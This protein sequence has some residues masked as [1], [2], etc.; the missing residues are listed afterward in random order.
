MNIL[1]MTL[2]QIIQAIGHNM[3]IDLVVLSGA[4]NLEAIV[5]QVA[6]NKGYKGVV[7]WCDRIA[8]VITFVFDVVTTAV[9][10]Q[11][12]KAVPLVFLCF[13]LVFSMGCASSGANG[14]CGRISGQGLT[15]PYVGGKANV[16]G[17]N[18]HVGCV[19]KCTPDV[20]DALT[21]QMEAYVDSQT[22][23]GKIMTTSPGI[24]TFTPSK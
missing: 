6:V 24:I 1:D 13:G 21:A 15:V 11:A 2:R 7:S 20:Y 12:P 22:T 4:L 14:F 10:K 18:C 19:G 23:N 8:S 9:K 17:F 16:D 3:A 5:R